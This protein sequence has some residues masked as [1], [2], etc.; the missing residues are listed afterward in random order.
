MYLNLTGE[1]KGSKLKS[2]YMNVVNIITLSRVALTLAGVL[3]IFS[4]NIKLLVVAYIIMSLSEVSDIVDGYVARRDKLVTDLGKIL[5]PLSDSISRFFYFFALAYHGLFP[6]WFMVFFFFRDIIVAYIR[7]FASFSGTVMSARLSGKIKGGVQFA[8]V[9]LLMYALMINTLQNGGKLTDSF[10]LWA[11]IIGVG[12]NILV[13]LYFRIKGGLLTTIV[14]LMTVLGGMLY[15]LKYVNFTVNYLTTFS[16][17]F[18][19]ISVTLYS[20]VDYLFSLDPT[21]KRRYN[22]IT[23]VSLIVMMFLISPYFL[24]LIKNKIESDAVEVKW[25]S[26]EIAEIEKNDNLKICGVI[27]SNDK[28]IVAASRV[29]ELSR[30]YIY[31]GLGS[32]EY[33]FYVDLPNPITN[34]KDIEQIGDFI[35]LIDDNIN[36]VIQIE[37][38]ELFQNRKVK[39]TKEFYTGFT[40]SA[41]L[42]AVNFNS[43]NYL[44]INDYIYSGNLYFCLIDGLNQNS[45]L[46]VQTNFKIKSEFYIKNLFSKGGYLYVLTNKIGKDLIYMVAAERAVFGGNLQSG[47]VKII[48]APDTDQVGISLV[49]GKIVS[50]GNHSKKIYVEDK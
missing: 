9:Y 24:D 42:C 11:T 44:V 4:G 28:I 25:K 20:L 7:I 16:I 8:G 32:T 5:D 23:G 29:H 41:T 18:I 30:L 35:Y 21:I 43:M 45:D 3:L 15:A 31:S 6:I 27:S 38:N 46:I 49:E 10:I 2:Q 1:K 26:Y 39:I 33:E 40:S 12:L 14:V 37:K 17:S 48:K 13:V 50:Y 36:T 34:V 47:I 22:V 19:V